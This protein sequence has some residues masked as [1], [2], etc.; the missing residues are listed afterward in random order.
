MEFV[1]FDLETTGFGDDSAICEFAFV[2]FVDGEV[3][4]TLSSLVKP[5]PNAVWLK[6][7][8]E[9]NGIR[10]ADV[11]NAPSLTS[12][13]PKIQ[14]FIGDL[15]VVAHNASFDVNAWVSEGGFEIE[16]FCTK[17]LA[18]HIVG[19]ES[20]LESLAR[21][22]KVPVERL[23]RAADDAVICGKVFQALVRATSA[24]TLGS[25]IG[26]HPSAL[27]KPTHK[28][29][30]IKKTSSLTEHSMSK[31][32]FDSL[33]SHPLFGSVTNSHL[34][35]KTVIF[36]KTRIVKATAGQIAM[37]LLGGFSKNHVDKATD[38]LVV[39]D[40]SAVETEPTTKMSK[41]LE[42]S[43]QGCK[44]EIISEEEFLELLSTSGSLE[45]LISR[46]V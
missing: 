38:Y 29:K 43:N 22:F 39:P 37:A 32:E 13:L 35:G 1:A 16:S 40:I 19:S 23:H 21:H 26:L 42:L 28:S 5:G 10:K 3:K 27:V 17:V 36:S 41:A 4:D 24:A 11:Q 31:G 6:S 45:D 18:K 44:V 2:K 12:L 30:T 33:S 20:T 7:A 14:S 46:W 15:P 34:S 8:A 25:L 9:K